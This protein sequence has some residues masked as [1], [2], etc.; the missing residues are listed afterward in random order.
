[1]YN[2]L[3]KLLYIFIIDCFMFRN[4]KKIFNFFGLKQSLFQRV[5]YTV[6]KHLAESR[7][8]EF[9]WRQSWGKYLQNLEQRILLIVT[10]SSRI[11]HNMY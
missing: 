11:I 8:L 10:N 7:Q 6:K 4:K 3:N 2:C 5:H 9:K 1:M